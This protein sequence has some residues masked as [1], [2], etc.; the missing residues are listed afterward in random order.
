[1][2]FERQRSSSVLGLFATTGAVADG[3]LAPSHSGGSSTVGASL[4]ESLESAAQ[5]AAAESADGVGAADGP[6]HASA[7]QA[8]ARDVLA[9]G[10]DH[11]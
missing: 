11:A 10:L 8:H 4:P 5:A 7:L 3:T 1:M 6:V 2:P 9:A